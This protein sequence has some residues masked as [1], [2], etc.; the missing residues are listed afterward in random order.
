MLNKFC[1]VKWPLN[2]KFK[3]TAYAKN[4]FLFTVTVGVLVTLSFICPYI[5][6]M[7]KNS[8]TGLCLQIFILTEASFI[9]KLSSLTL[10]IIKVITIISILFMFIWLLRILFKRNKVLILSNC[11]GKERTKYISLSLLIIVGFNFLAWMPFIMVFSLPLIGNIV[12]YDLLVWV[13]IMVVPINST[14]DPILLNLLS[15]DMRRYLKGWVLFFTKSY[16]SKG[17]L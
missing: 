14:L 1:V 12:H 8:P 9:L 6:V 11:K 3:N 16:F 5:V 17:L 13:I 10:I 15:P 4:V 7:E 2:S